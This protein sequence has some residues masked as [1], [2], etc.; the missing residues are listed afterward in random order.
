MKTFMHKLTASFFG[1]ALIVP[2]LAFV[3][4]AEE[5]APSA[6][7][8]QPATTSPILEVGD[9]EAAASQSLNV[10]S[11]QGPSSLGFP[12]S[13]VSQ[14]GLLGDLV[15]DSSTGGIWVPFWKVINEIGGGIFRDVFSSALFGIDVK[16][17]GPQTEDPRTPAIGDQAVPAVINLDETLPKPDWWNWQLPFTPYGPRYV[18]AYSNAMQR[19]IPLV[20]VPAPDS[21]TPR[22]VVYAMS[23][24]D[25][26]EEAFS[27]ISNTDLV[28]IAQ[29][30]NVHVVSPAQGRATN[31]LDWYDDSASPAGKQQWETFLT[32]ELPL[33]FENAIG[34]SH[35]RSIVGMSASAG[36]A[37]LFAE[38][39]PGMYDAV[40]S[41]SGCA[42]SN[43][44]LGRYAH[45]RSLEPNATVDEV[46]GPQDE[47]FSLYNDAYVNAPTLVNQPNIFV[48]SA[49][50]LVGAQDFDDYYRPENDAQWNSRF[51][52]GGLIEAVTNF[53]THRLEAK[54]N[55]SGVR[56]NFQYSSA[57]TH[58]W[59]YFNQ[60]AIGFMDMLRKVY[61][62]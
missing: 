35:Q 47:A 55:I 31:Y 7:E 36:T 28:K 23:G 14:N 38:H 10:D 34:A 4:N 17:Y 8:V 1:V 46:F 44:N 57:G 5:L 15:F 18:S 58:S 6:A 3:S 25:G 32:K 11:T 26:G 22:P 52:I 54:M 9:A 56:A 50:G 61:A 60:G 62:N 2:S 13:S 24:R 59:G 29:E 30:L 49:D 40:G 53:C 33:S 37:L 16:E 43:S 45:A 41:I 51:K 48:F 12:G 39:N 42:E 19:D 20:W 21:S 27:L